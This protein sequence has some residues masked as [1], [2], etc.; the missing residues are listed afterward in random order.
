MIP[1]HAEPAGVMIGS[2]PDKL[3]IDMAHIT[4]SAEYSP[5]WLQERCAF[6]QRQ[7]RL[8]DWEITPTYATSHELRGDYAHSQVNGAL[9]E[10]RMRILDPN[11][12]DPPSTR[13]GPYDVEQILIHELLHLHLD[14]WGGDARDEKCLEFREKEAAIDCMSWALLRLERGERR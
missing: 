12:A 14:A 2:S 4:A 3:P 13:T 5:A 10:S 11:D 9:K 7:L 8:S 1:T 6:W